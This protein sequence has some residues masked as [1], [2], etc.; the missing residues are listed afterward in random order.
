MARGK[1]PVVM[2]F[3]FIFKG[4]GLTITRRLELRH[5][6]MSG[7]YRI[8]PGGPKISKKYRQLLIR[9]TLIFKVDITQ[10][11]FFTGGGFEKKIRVD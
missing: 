11:R 5:G 9:Y 6:V 1:Q 10:K 2:D 7:E 3:R 8:M 4:P